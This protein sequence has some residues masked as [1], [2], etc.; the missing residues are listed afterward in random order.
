MRD[1]EKA[2]RFMRESG[3]TELQIERVLTKI[4]PSMYKPIQ[5][6]QIGDLWKGQK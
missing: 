5:I 1:V 6:P 2:K 3:L 4:F